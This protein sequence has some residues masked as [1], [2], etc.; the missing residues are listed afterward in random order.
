MENKALVVGLGIAGM[1]A[2][3]GL[4]KAGWT[5]VIIERAP[6][7]RTGGYFIGLF[8]EGI[9][10]A[11]DLGII[12]HLHSRNPEGNGN[13]W[14]LGRRGN[15]TP[16]LGFL[17]QPG[18]PAAVLRGDI[19]AALWQALGMPEASEERVEVRYATV[20]VEITQGADGVDVLLTDE[21]TGRQYQEKFDLVVGADGMR[22]TVRRMVFGPDERYLTDWNSMI[23]AFELHEQ[24]PSYD[25][26]DSVISARFKRAA[27]VFGLADRA[28]TA[29]L[30]YRLARGEEI[31]AQFGG[32]PVE[33]LRE[34]FAGMDD[35]VVR[36]LL[37][38]LEQTPEYLYDS[39]HQVNMSR[40][41]KGRVVLVGDAA[42]CLNL[43]SGMGA[44]SALR[45][46]A[47]LGKALGEHPDKIAA[48]LEAWEKRLRPFITKHQRAARLKQ[49][50]FVPSSRLVE[51]LRLVVL[52]LLRKVRNCRTADAA[53]WPPAPGT[54]Q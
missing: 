43:Y 11:V 27:W 25:R 24:V 2:A 14:S 42:W 6:K 15:R 20:P 10:A 36:H 35:P 30:T 45:G 44:T 17:D 37:D 50:L 8:P 33:R 7:R 54:I 19:E 29:L 53:V 48:A 51:G 21:A 31:D 18:E 3:I 16:T 39:V 9:R 13:T 46:G 52:G 5:P 22:S 41:T 40:W 34:V 49:Q 12:D 38:S 1:S 28:P 32:R 47:E 23:C 26:A 4:R